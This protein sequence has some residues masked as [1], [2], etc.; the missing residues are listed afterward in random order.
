MVLERHC[1]GL[2]IS[3]VSRLRAVALLG[4]SAASRLRAVALI[5]GCS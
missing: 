5:E 1:V 4:L 3:T 2:R